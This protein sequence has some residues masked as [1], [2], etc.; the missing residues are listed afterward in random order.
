MRGMGTITIQAYTS[1]L[2]VWQGHLPEFCAIYAKAHTHTPIQREP[3]MH[4][5]V[6]SPGLVVPVVVAVFPVGKQKTQ[7]PFSFPFL[8][9]FFVWLY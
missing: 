4:A 2:P 5:Y 1:R 7:I 3:N 9:F 6:L 8:A